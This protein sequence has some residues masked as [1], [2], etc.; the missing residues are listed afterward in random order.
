MGNHW[1]PLP[2]W[3][4]N[5]LRCIWC[6]LR[7]HRHYIH[8]LMGLISRILQNV[9]LKPPIKPTIIPL[10]CLLHRLCSHHKCNWHMNTGLPYCFHHNFRTQAVFKEETEQTLQELLS[11]VASICSPVYNAR[12]TC[13]R[14]TGGNPLYCQLYLYWGPPWLQ[15]DRQ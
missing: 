1:R 6:I 3:E 15:W 14:H 10:K 4:K 13:P 5:L 8:I 2:V 11:Q 7:I 9:T 12:H